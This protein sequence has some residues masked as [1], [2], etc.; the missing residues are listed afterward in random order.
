MSELISSSRSS[1]LA[2]HASWDHWFEEAVRLRDVNPLR[3]N[4]CPLAAVLL[5]STTNRSIERFLLAKGKI[6]TARAGLAA[7]RYWLSQLS[8]PDG[9]PGLARMFPE[10]P[11]SD[12]FAEGHAMSDVL[13]F[14]CGISELPH[15]WRCGMCA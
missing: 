11:L 3:P 6:A 10:V 1:P 13:P 4:Y 9:V 8:P 2:L 12:P 14:P 5:F 15:F 7:R